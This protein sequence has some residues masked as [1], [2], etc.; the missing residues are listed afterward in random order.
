M[1]AQTKT[2]YK[3]KTYSVP[4]TEITLRTVLSPEGA[5]KRLLLLSKYKNKRRKKKMSITSGKQNKK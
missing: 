4:A 5:W 3:F 1:N 2:N